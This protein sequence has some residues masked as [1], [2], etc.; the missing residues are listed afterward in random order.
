[1]NLLNTSIKIQNMELKNRLVMPPMAISKADENGRV[2]SK[3]LDYYEEKSA[4]GYIGLIIA[5]H[6]YVSQEGKAGKGQLSISDD[7]DIS[8]LQ[9]LVSRVH[10]NGTKIMAQISHAGGAAAYEVTGLEQIS[11][12]SVPM[13]KRSMTAPRGN[14]SLPREMN[15]TDIKNTVDNF[16]RAAQRAKIAG[17][18]GVEIH[19][20]HGYLLNQ[21]YSPLTNQRTDQYSGKTIQGRIRLHLEIIRAIRET[22]GYDYPLALRLGACDYMEGGSTIQDSMIAAKEFEIEGIDCIDVS[23]GF[24]GYLNPTSHKPGYFDELSNAIKDKV[25]IPVILTGG[26]VDGE[27][28]EMLLEQKKADLIGVGRA[29]LKDSDWAK[30][31]MIG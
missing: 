18:D 13:P 2:T 3:T 20:A 5:E 25:S 21:F 19:S 7:G 30:N 29:I 22:V 8:G 31:T 28:A 11:A 26:I 23:G 16:A 1:M 9:Q 27:T 24:C 15:L 17:F 6:S 12:S 14:L 4:G 10:K